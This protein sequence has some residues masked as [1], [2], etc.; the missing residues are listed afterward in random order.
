MRWADA[1]VKAERTPV[2]S[3]Q[4]PRVSVGMPVYNGEEF[5]GSALESILEQ[6]FTDL[7]L[8]ISDNASTDS[9]EAM[10][11]K[12]ASADPR[13]K[14]WRNTENVGATENYNA[15]FRYARGAYFKW[16]SSNDLCHPAFIEE[17]VAVLERRPDVV[18]VY[19]RTQLIY[20]ATKPPEDYD[21]VRN[22]LQDSACARFKTLL[23]R[24]RL[25]NMMNGVI[26][27]AVLGRTPLLKNFFSSDIS[28]MAEVALFGKFVELPEVMFYRRMD[29]KSATAKKSDEEVLR[30]HNPRQHRYCS[31]HGSSIMPM[32][33]RSGAHR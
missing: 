21:D 26:R 9:T 5:L 15:V 31:R 27:S 19:P 24:I 29:A 25:N 7:E 16:A 30:H 11:R 18:L 6:T 20:D 23:D 22:L 1:S 2:R 28:L 10:C 4:A 17:S 3:P 33:R 32:H 8:V 14:Y 12:Y 13:V